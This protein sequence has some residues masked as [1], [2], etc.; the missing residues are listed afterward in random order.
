MR[1]ISFPCT[2]L[3]N[4][5]LL[6]DISYVRHLSLVCYGLG[7]VIVLNFTPPTIDIRRYVMLRTYTLGGQGC[8]TILF[9]KHHYN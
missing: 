2:D 1:N 9:M 6:I 3:A 4:C 8:C 7:R 5:R